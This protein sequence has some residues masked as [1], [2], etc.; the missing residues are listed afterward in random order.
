MNEIIKHQD[1]SIT[2]GSLNTYVEQNAKTFIPNV[3]GRIGALEDFTVFNDVKTSIVIPILDDTI[4]LVPA[5]SCT[6][7]VDYGTSSMDGVTAT[8]VPLKL[9]RGFCLPE[10][11]RYFPNWFPQGSNHTV[12]PQEQAFL[13][14]IWTQLAYQVEYDCFNSGDGV[15][16]IIAAATA[17]G[18]TVLA[19]QSFA[20]STAANNGIIA[21][22]D[23]MVANVDSKIRS[24]DDLII[25][26]GD[27]AFDNYTL[28]VRN[29]NWYHFSP[30]EMDNGTVKMFGKRNVKIRSTGVLDGKNMALLHK[31]AW[32]GFVYDK[33]PLSET[34]NSGYDLYLDKYI[35]RVMLKFNTVILRGNMA[36]LAKA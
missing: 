13:D 34:P 26:L 12:V 29:L 11:E 20:V 15:T 17:S 23:N 25:F 27:D 7:F 28:S 32:T 16:G 8:V 14:S 5:S 2:Y 6:S 4:K 31:K 10:M 36:V 19:T 21:T 9:E 22:L 3:I 35:F 33:N 30:D 1:F 18:C 24:Q